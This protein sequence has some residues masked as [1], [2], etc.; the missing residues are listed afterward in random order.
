MSIHWITVR[1]SS[2]LRGRP[3]SER[4]DRLAFLGGPLASFAS[5]SH[6][7]DVLPPKSFPDQ[8]TR[9]E[10]GLHPRICLVQ[11]AKAASPLN[12]FS[13]RCGQSL[14]SLDEFAFR[15]L[16]VRRQRAANGEG[17][18]KP[19]WQSAVGATPLENRGRCPAGTSHADAVMLGRAAKAALKGA[20]TPGTNSFSGVSSGFLVTTDA[21][22]GSPSA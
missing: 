19:P 8:P 4:A 16:G 21:S 17:V 1:S 22:R 12:T 7:R 9:A 2:S 15:T 20:A 13:R 11:A 3:L 10:L 5:W 14:V 18:L 6:G